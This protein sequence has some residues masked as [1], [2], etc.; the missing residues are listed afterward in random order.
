MECSVAR[1]TRARRQQS[2]AKIFGHAMREHKQIASGIS[3][4]AMKG[5][6]CDCFSGG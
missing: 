1:R 3:S 6:R 2:F 5:A 4:F